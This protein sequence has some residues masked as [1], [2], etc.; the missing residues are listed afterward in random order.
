LV[1]HYRNAFSP[2]PGFL[3][4][5]HLIELGLGFHINHPIDQFICQSN[6]EALLSNGKR[7]L[8]VLDNRYCM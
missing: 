7:E 4:D 8:T 5:I 1:H 3:G 2:E 6:I